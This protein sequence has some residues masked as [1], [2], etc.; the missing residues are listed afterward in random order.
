[1][2]HFHSTITSIRICCICVVKGSWRHN[3]SISQ[4]CTYTTNWNCKS[5]TDI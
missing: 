1:M 3:N 4:I 2:K 5:A